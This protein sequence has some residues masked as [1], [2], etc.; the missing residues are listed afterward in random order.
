SMSAPDADGYSSGDQV[1]LGLSS[2]LFSNSAPSA[3]TAVV[4]AGD[5]E[6]GRAVIDPAIVDNTDE[7]G[8]ASVAITIPAGTPAGILMLTV[9][10]PEAGTSIEVPIT[11]TAVATVI[12]NVTAPVISGK[13]KI[14]R[15][16]TATEGTWSVESPILAFQ[17]NRNGTAIASATAASYTL[18]APDAG[19]KITVTVTASKEGSLDGAA[20][21]AEVSVPKLRSST[22]GSTNST[23]V[24]GNQPVTYTV[25]VRGDDG[26]VATGEVAIYDGTRKITTVT[27]TTADNGRITVPVS[28]G[29]GIHLLTAR[30]LGSDS[31]QG[32]IGSPDPVIRF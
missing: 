3:G 19:A 2:L 28:L 21:S 20:T 17:W 5:V 6:L 24:F 31:L 26:V 1:T 12:E 11:V 22:S 7:G 4:S 30:Y 27:L 14:G 16:L 25:T 8:R 10:V 13:P 23:V 32:S 9:S 15:T 29:R 18:V